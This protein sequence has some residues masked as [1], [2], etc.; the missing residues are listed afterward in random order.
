MAKFTLVIISID[1]DEIFFIILD[2]SIVLIWFNKIVKFLFNPE[3]LLSRKTF[4]GNSFLYNLEV[5][6]I[7]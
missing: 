4:L 1:K 6:C 5:I 3:C 7:K 2:L